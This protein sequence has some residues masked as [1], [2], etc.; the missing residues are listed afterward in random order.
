MIDGP[1]IPECD[2]S[3]GCHGVRVR[4]PQENA[5]RRPSGFRAGRRAE[6]IEE[7]ALAGREEGGDIAF[8]EVRQALEDNSIQDWPTVLEVSPKSCFTDIQQ[9]GEVRACRVAAALVEERLQPQMCEELRA[10]HVA[11]E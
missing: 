8:K 1:V 3:A 7:A 6:R 11:V 10:A 9:P 2:R 5:E 4:P